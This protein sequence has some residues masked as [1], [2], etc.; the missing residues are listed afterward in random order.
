MLGACQ[1]EKGVV[2][3]KAAIDTRK[4]KVKMD[5]E[6][7]QANTKAAISKR[8]YELCKGEL[9]NANAA[10]NAV[11]AEAM[12][13]ESQLA[14]TMANLAKKAKTMRQRITVAVS[15]KIHDEEREIFDKKLDKAV[16]NLAKKKPM[17]AKCKVCAKLSGQEK[18]D[19]KADCGDCSIQRA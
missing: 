6:V 1:Q 7:T 18:I 9:Q 11:K 13:T 10:S 15:G 19:L 3:Q 16:N 17:T 8:G 5:G 4:L 12:A 2:V 14:D